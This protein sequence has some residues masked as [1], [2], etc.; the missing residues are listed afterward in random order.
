VQFTKMPPILQALVAI[1]VVMA[2]IWDWR[3]RRIPNWLTFSSVI[4]GIG[5]NA[6]MYQTSGVWLSLK[7]LGLALLIYF[8]LFLLRGMGAGDVKLMAALGAIVGWQNWLGILI[9]TAIF[10]G[11]AALVV[12]IVNGRLRKTLENIWFIG[13]SIRKREAPYAGNPQLDVRT[14]QGVRL[15]HGVVIAFGTVAFLAA[16]S[17]LGYS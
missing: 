10:G 2:G 11:I 1:L 13:L 5:L 16:T 6:L 12:V 4:L 14:D 3:T 17:V 8:P 15:P 7:G 9:V